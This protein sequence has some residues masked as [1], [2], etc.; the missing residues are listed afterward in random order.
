MVYP[1]ILSGGKRLFPDS[2]KMATL[3]LIESKLAG[4]GIVMLTYQGA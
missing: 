3:K 2:G 4:D 1:V